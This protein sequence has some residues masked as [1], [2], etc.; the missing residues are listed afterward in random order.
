MV[1]NKYLSMSLKEQ[2]EARKEF[3]STDEGKVLKP[4]LNRLIVFAVILFA[5]GIYIIIDAIKAGN[6]HLQVF[7]GI[8]ILVASFIFIIGRYYVIVKRVNSYLIDRIAKEQKVKKELDKKP[9]KK[10]ATKK[11]TAKKAK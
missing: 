7:Y 2:K 10:T 5:W 3:F 11:T 1:K 4:R 9:A 6:M 8:L